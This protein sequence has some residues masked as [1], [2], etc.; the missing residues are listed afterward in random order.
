MNMLAML[1]RWNCQKN[2]MGVAVSLI[3]VEERGWVD[4]SAENSDE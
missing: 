1:S 4:K 2:D 3:A